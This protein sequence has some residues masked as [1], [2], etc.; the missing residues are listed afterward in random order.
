MSPLHTARASARRS[1]CGYNVQRATCNV[2]ALGTLS[3]GGRRCVVAGADS[4]SGVA[5]TFYVQRSTFNPLA[6]PE[7]PS[8][9]PS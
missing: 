5:A 4:C 9:T 7:F 8:E 3:S 2:P 6:T 1:G